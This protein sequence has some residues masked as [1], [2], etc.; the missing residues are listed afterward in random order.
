MLPRLVSNSWTQ[1][2]HL[3][4][5]PKVLRLQAGTTAPSLLYDFLNDICLCIYFW[6]RVSLCH[7]GWSAMT[8]SQLTAT[9]ASQVQ[10]ILLSASWLAGITG[11]HH[12]AWL[13]FVL[14]VDRI[15]PCW[16]GWSSTPDL[17]W[18][19]HLSLPKCCDYKHE[20]PHPARINL[21]F[22]RV[23]INLGFID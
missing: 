21:R 15:S 2:T 1:A 7:P 12:Y 8:W 19:A 13:I 5:P 9:S 11:M 16:P 10:V 22:S 23:N 17:K 18:Y 3:P 6:D 4:L 14:L 20:P